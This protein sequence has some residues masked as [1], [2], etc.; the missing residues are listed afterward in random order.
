MGDSSKARAALGWSPRAGFAELVKIMVEHDLEFA[1][2]EKTLRDAGHLVGL[3]R[4]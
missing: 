4:G 1:R 2:Q 3:A